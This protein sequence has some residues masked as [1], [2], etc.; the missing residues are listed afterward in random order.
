VIVYEKGDPRVA[1]REATVVRSGADTTAY[2]S[3][4]V[5]E[6]S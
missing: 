6:V 3:V 4:A 5:T 2:V 1:E